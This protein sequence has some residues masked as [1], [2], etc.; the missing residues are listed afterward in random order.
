M[1]SLINGLLS[2]VFLP[3]LRKK[4]ACNGSL[5]CYLKQKNQKEYNSR[6]QTSKYAFSTFRILRKG[7]GDEEYS[8]ESYKKKFVISGSERE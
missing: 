3:Q 5:P 7:Q 6:S 2:L 4:K 1:Q 8:M